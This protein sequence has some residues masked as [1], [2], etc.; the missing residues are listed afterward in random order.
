MRKIIYLQNVSLDGFIEDS[1]G[2][3]GWTNPGEELHRHFNEQ[4]KKV[5]T[6]LY[7]RRMHEIMDAWTKV[8]QDPSAPDYI[9]EYARLWKKVD[10]IVFSKTL[11]EP[12]YDARLMREVV[13][14]EIMQWKNEPGKD[15]SVGGAGLAK[16]FMRLN[17]IDEIHTYIYPVVL[18]GGKPM[19]PELKQK[20]HLQL[21]ETKAFG[22]GVVLLR[23]QSEKEPDL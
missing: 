9:L 15:I 10:K 3:I 6:H 1:D 16:T 7:G 8:E 23:Y 12:K 18:G 11:K 14:E 2:K 22:N 20:L 4:E 5:D 21:V 17:L 19:F 13:P